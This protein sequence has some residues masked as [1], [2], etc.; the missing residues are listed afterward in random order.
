MVRN[1]LKFVNWKQRK[2][3]AADLKAI[4]TSTTVEAGEQRL[5]EFEEKWNQTLAPIGLSWRRNWERIIPFFGYPPEIKNVIYT[6]NAIESINMS[7]R[8]ITKNRGS[9]P[10]NG[11]LAEG[12]FFTTNEK[13]GGSPN[14]HLSCALT[15]KTKWRVTTMVRSVCWA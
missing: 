12:Q 10:S 13:T 5:T 4:Y 11:S 3:V 2:E 7:L 15:T 6:T 14:S 1:S 8:K 9:F